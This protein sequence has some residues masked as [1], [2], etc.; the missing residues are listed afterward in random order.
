MKAVQ[1]RI[2]QIKLPPKKRV[3]IKCKPRKKGKGKH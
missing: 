3:A 2:L 1:I